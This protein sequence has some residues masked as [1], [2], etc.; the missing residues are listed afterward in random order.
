MPKGVT[1]SSPPSY[2]QDAWDEDDWGYEDQWQQS[3]HQQDY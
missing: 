3:E 1:A 2:G